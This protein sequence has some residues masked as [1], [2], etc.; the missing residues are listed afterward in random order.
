MVRNLLQE[1]SAI[2]RS[3]H[4][5]TFY[6]GKFVEQPKQC[7][8][9]D[10]VLAYLPGNSMAHFVRTN[11][12]EIATDIGTMW[13]N[14]K[15]NPAMAMAQQAEKD[16]PTK[17][18]LPMEY[19]VYQDVFE[20]K[21]A[22]RFPEA[23]PYDHAIDLKDDFV[24]KDCKV[25]PLSPME[26][27]KLDEFLDENLR[28]G[29]IRPSKSPMAS[30]FFFVGKKD[31]SL[32]PCQD[33][34]YLNEG[35]VKNAYPLPLIAE[36]VDQLQG[37]QIFTKLD[38][39]S[40]YN[41]V[42]IKDGDQWKAA[43]K[44]NH[45]LFEPTVMFFGLCNSPATFQAMMNN[46]FRDML[47]EGWITI[48]MD[49]MLIHSTNLEEHRQRTKRVLQRLRDNDLFLKLEKCQFVVPEVEFLGAIVSHNKVT[50]DPIKIKGILEWPTPKNV[51]QVRGF[52]GFGNFY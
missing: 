22:E 12:E 35:T 20:K 49:D 5:A 7:D 11:E 32:R 27:Q 18:K 17:G 38:L 3:I 24:P 26:Q 4:I 31:G 44:T 47:I 46:L 16:N 9:D 6:T 39:R 21:A 10:Y 33:Y 52:L 43:F 13:I 30:P 40:G 15:V 8:D 45:G 41:N 25:Y 29:Y 34:R 23:R 19:Q 14:A 51:K 28:K 36:L 37:S 2:D 42:R 1:R 50:M 48:Y